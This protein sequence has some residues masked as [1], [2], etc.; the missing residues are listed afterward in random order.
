MSGEQS[1][2]IMNINYFGR[3]FSFTHVAALN[4]FGEKH[5]Y[6]HFPSITDTIDACLTDPGALSVVPIENTTGGI[7]YDT[8]DTLA[9][10][11]FLNS[12]LIILEELELNIKLFLFGKK[13]M[14][15][16]DIK[17]IYSHEYVLKRSE[18]WIKDNIPQRVV[19]KQVV[20]TSDAAQRVKKG[21]YCCAIASM[22]AGKYYKLNKLAEIDFLGKKCNITRFF[23]L[24]MRRKK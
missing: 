20:S 15:I 14:K 21:K 8:V 5:K 4:R 23:I 18:K 11:K 19:L 13:G 7:I 17:K 1:E 6:R 16:R 22:E 9:A 12:G 24:K 3:P 10:D 2:K